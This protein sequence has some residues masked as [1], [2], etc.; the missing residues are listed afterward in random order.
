MEWGGDDISIPKRNIE[1][2]H[3]VKV[4]IVYKNV[5]SFGMLIR[6]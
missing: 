5:N 6:D 4:C 3:T 2:N 1:S